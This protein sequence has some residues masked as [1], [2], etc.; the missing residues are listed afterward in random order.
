M[1]DKRVNEGD[2]AAILNLIQSPPNIQP[3]PENPN[4]KQIFDGGLRTLETGITRYE[5]SDGTRASVA[6]LPVLCVSI[7]FPNGVKIRI[8]QED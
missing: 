5:F 1:W 2:V 4:F 7:V 8:N 3:H 6:V